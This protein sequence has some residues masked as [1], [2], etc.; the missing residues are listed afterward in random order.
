MRIDV[1]NLEESAGK[2]SQIYEAGQ[3]SFEDV[4]FTLIT[5]PEVRGRVR[6]KDA[7]VEVDGR[8]QAK[9][10]VQ[11]ARCLKNVEFPINV[12]FTERFVPAVDWRHEDQHELHEEDLDLAVFDGQSIELDDVIR[13]EILLAV[14]S[15][16]LCAEDCKGLCPTCGIDRNEA[17]C[18][19]DT[20]VVD[21]RWEKL[22]D[23]KR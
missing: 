2:F 3:L 16:V 22:K 1:E 13:E 5:P 23:L 15:H 12:E 8:L 7:G 17:T 21:E 6:R 11:C 20:K 4:D 19:C 10:S 18:A 9:L 14:P